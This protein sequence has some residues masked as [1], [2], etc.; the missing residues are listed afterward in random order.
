MA[1]FTLSTRDL[2]VLEKIRDPESDPTRLPKLDA[3]APVDPHIDAD[4]YKSLEAQQQRILKSILAAERT[5]AA[6]PATIVE[7][8]TSAV[9]EWDKQIDS[10]P[11]Y[12]RARCNRAQ[13]LRRLYGDSIALDGCQDALALDAPQTSDDR[14]RKAIVIM[15]DLNT[16]IR[17]LSPASPT[18]PLSPQT[19]QTLANA[20]TQLATIYRR[21][22]ELASQGHAVD[23]DLRDDPLVAGSTGLDLENAASANFAKGGR[24]GNDIAKALAV[25]TNPTAKLCG[26]IVR[27]AMREEYG[28]GYCGQ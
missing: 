3:A 6:A 15:D 16:C 10:H 13:A 24:Y 20:H 26:E 7:A 8:Y 25:H 4:T 28:A 27:S 11:K 9:A 23:V 2:N 5:Q 21:T 12:A 17:L 18:A 19:A 1:D 14:R 22:A